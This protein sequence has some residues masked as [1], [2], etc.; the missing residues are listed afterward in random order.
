MSGALIIFYYVYS[1]M[2]VY[3]KCDDLDSNTT[4][5]ALSFPH[6]SNTNITLSSPAPEW[7]RITTLVPVLCIIVIL[8]VTNCILPYRYPNSIQMAHKLIFLR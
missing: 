1:W 5:P 6:C 7:C 8:D 2:M 3:R 4:L